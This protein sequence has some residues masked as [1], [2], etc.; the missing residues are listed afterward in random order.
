MRVIVKVNDLEVRVYKNAADRRRAAA[1]ITGYKVCFQD[2]QG[3]AIQL[4]RGGK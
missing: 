4:I 1:Q 2:V 3:P